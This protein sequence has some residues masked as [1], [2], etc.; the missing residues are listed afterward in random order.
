MKSI[1]NSH[2]VAVMNAIYGASLKYPEFLSEAKEHIISHL[3]E[4]KI[5]E[6]GEMLLAYIGSEHL[7]IFEKIESEI[8]SRKQQT[9]P[10][11]ILALLQAFAYTELGS[12]EFF[13]YLEKLVTIKSPFL[14]GCW[15]E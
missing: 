4:L 9:I 13:E 15:E 1:D 6:M 12:P 2:L 7:D 10:Q 14:I 5:E 8:L 3:S 11:N